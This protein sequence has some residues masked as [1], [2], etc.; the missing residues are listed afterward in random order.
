MKGDDDQVMISDSV[1]C[2]TYY[3][4]HLLSETFL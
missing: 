3:M 2:N 1:A 4:S